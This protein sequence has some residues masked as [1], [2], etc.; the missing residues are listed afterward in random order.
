MLK[1]RP[2]H[3]NYE[4]EVDPLTEDD[5]TTARLDLLSAYTMFGTLQLDGLLAYSA[6]AKPRGGRSSSPNRRAAHARGRRRLLLQGARREHLEGRVSQIPR[7][8]R[9]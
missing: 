5:P 8:T 3:S 1:T 2:H 7:P 9:I 6:R 4:D